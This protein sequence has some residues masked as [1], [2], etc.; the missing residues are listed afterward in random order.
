VLSFAEASRSVSVNLSTGQW[1]YTARIMPLGDSITSGT[2]S[3]KGDGY[4]G[5]LS[6]KFNASSIAVDFVGSHRD[7]PSS[8]LDREHEGVP[9]LRADDLVPNVRSLMS[10]YYPDIV[11]L[12]IG[13]NDIEQEGRRGVSNLRG[14]ISSI[15]DDIANTLPNTTIFLSTLPPIKPGVA[16]SSL[17]PA[18]NVAIK[19]AAADAIAK[20]QHVSLVMPQLTVR[21]LADADHPTAAGYA[22]LAENWY[23]AATAAIPARG[24]TLG[25]VA[26]P[27]A[28]GE[29][30]VVGSRAGDRIVGSEDR[31]VLRANSGNDVVFGGSGDD[32]LFGDKGDDRLYGDG[33]NDRLSGGTGRDYLNG[34]V[35][36][37]AFVFT[38]LSD[39][40]VAARD[41]ITGFSRGDR[42]DLL[43]IDANSS[44]SGNQRFAFVPDFTGVA[45]QLQWDKTSSGFVVTGDVNGD[46]I[47]DFAVQVNTS[48]SALHRFDFVL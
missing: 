44:V 17:V 30:D 46:A 26:A 12:M 9:G 31:N 24:G 35:G 18:A 22:K 37:D 15:L 6:Q 5:P 38:K 27:I 41:V 34:G 16:G 8:F 23:V 45:G 21:D 11:L 13:S 14:E 33:G 40:L 29:M 47:A 7:G 19:S 48:L 36:N 42:V 25:G 3:P 32:A 1:S 20:G 28:P 4:R 10:K 39:S 2:A 43:A